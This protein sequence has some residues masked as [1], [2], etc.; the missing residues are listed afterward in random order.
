MEPENGLNK[1]TKS[2][3]RFLSYDVFTEISI[4]K[5]LNLLRMGLCPFALIPL[6]DSI[7]HP[8]GSGRMSMVRSGRIRDSSNAPQMQKYPC[9]PPFSHPATNHEI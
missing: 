3:R 1:E 5:R 7:L 8:A 9:G 2:I 4:L 6:P